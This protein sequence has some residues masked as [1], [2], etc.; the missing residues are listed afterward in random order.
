MGSGA[1]TETEVFLLA[2]GVAVVLLLM[3]FDRPIRAAIR[4]LRRRLN[5]ERR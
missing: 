2:A 4:K 5:R 3:T 1:I